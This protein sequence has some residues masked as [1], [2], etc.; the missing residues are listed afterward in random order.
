MKNAL[1]LL[2]PRVKLIAHYPGCPWFVGAILANVEFGCYQGIGIDGTLKTVDIYEVEQSPLNFKKLE[3]WE[4]IP[5]AELPK[6]V[7]KTNQSWDGVIVVKQWN[8]SIA[9]SGRGPWSWR[10]QD[11]PNTEV[12]RCDDVT[13]ASEEEFNM[14][15][16]KR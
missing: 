13:P 7:I 9:G 1:D 14:Q 8:E 2:I 4:E 6:Y 3:W 16:N 10:L 12:V 11:G 5:L 15:Q